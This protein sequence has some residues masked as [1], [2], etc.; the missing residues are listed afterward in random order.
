MSSQRHQ[1]SSLFLIRL[2]SEG[3]EE[4]K[5]WRGRVQHVVTGEA[6]TFDEWAMLID[7]LLEMAETG[8]IEARAPQ[9]EDKEVSP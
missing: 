9:G 3:V 2:W 8:D 7:L 5:G 4:Q 6:R 1:G